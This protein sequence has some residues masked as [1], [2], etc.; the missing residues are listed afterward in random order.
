MPLTIIALLMMQAPAQPEPQQKPSLQCEGGPLHKNYGG[1]PWLVYSCSDS[2]T[3][4]VVSDAGNPAS[5]F[6]FVFFPKDGQYGMSGEGNG[7]KSASAAA[8]EDLKKLSTTD[9]LEMLQETR[10]A[11]KP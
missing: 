5:P 10:K 4:V 2:K 7:S 9:I 8:F 3:L 1:T 11:A 6:Y